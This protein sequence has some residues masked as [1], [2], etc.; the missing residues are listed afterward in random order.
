MIVKYDEKKIRHTLNEMIVED[1][2]PFLFVDANGFRKFM[3]VVEPRFNTPSHFTVMRDCVK[4]YLKNKS[5][6]K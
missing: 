6:L 2:L 3:K 4:M 5:D 1:E